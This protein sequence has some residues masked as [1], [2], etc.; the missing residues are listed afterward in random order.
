MR[1][2]DNIFQTVQAIIREAIIRGVFR[3]QKT[4]SQ[5]L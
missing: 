3:S 4:A 2:Y 1:A 5:F